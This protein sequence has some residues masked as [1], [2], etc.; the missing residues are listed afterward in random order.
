MT[1]FEKLLKIQQSVEVLVKDQEIKEGQKY[2]YVSSNL[3]V[4][5]IRPLMNE[6][7]LILIPRVIAAK[8]SSNETKTGTTR[9]MTELTME[10]EW[11]DCETGESYTVPFY[12]QGTDLAGEKGVGKAMTY[13]EK[14]FFLKLFHIATPN[15]D[16]DADQRTKTG[17]KAQHGTQAEK[18]NFVYFRKTITQIVNELCSGDAEKIA[19]SCV[20]ITK[21]DGRGYA[22]VDSVEGMKDA[23][24]PIIYGKAKAFYEKKMG[25]PFVYVPSEGEEVNADRE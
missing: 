23:A 9:Y 16:P 18:E 6:L 10:M 17:E 20:F 11:R 12:A 1:I 5:T 2:K 21:D 4:D 13:G 25:K 22:G 8:L 14:Y 24:L 19:K 3:V 15:D 7:K